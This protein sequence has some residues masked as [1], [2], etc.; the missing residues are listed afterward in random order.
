MIFYNS[1]I[2]D[3][4]L[5]DA[6]IADESTSFLSSGGKIEFSLLASIVFFQYQEVLTKRILWP[7]AAAIS[8]ALLV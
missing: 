6:I 7:S 4:P 2:P 5:I 8:N 1:P 3:S